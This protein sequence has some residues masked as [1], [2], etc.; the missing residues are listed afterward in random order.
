MSRLRAS[1][2]LVEQP[3]PEPA[4]ERSSWE[5]GCGAIIASYHTGSDKLSRMRDDDEN[6][7]K[8]EGAI[9]A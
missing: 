3:R 8:A 1:Y 5:H 7:V 2:S 6:L 9:S 4:L